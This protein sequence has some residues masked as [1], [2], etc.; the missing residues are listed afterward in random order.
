[1]SRWFHW[2]VVEGMIPAA[3]E[4][5]THALSVTKC[6]SRC[7]LTSASSDDIVRLVITMKLEHSTS[8]LH[9]GQTANGDSNVCK[10]GEQ[11]DTSADAWTQR[12]HLRRR[13]FLSST[14]SPDQC[15]CPC[16]YLS[17]S[18]V[19]HSGTACITCSLHSPRC[20]PRICIK[21]KGDTETAAVYITTKQP[22]VG[23]RQSI[24]IGDSAHR[25]FAQSRSKHTPQGQTG[26]TPGV[27]G[28]TYMG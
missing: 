18:R 24:N 25:L 16:C 12:I 9:P 19:I 22:R 3:K 13:C 10:D 27:Q 23:P 15:P 8:N 7:D 4:S 1:M 5:H 11:D 26:D 17:R 28:P 14:P 21:P 2:H 20:S 6:A